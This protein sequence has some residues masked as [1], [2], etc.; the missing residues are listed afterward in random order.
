MSSRP[1]SMN[2]ICSGA[3]HL[4]RVS[5]ERLDVVVGR[6]A[7]TNT[8]MRYSTRA[9]ESSNRRLG[10]SVSCRAQQPYAEATPR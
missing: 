5:W 9:S 4:S 6:V 10:G 3:A 8:E 2:A 7:L 1:L